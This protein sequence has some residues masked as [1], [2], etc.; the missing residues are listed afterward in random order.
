[1]QKETV[2]CVTSAEAMT[3]LDLLWTEY[4]DLS[5]TMNNCLNNATNM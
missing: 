5:L 3:G 2:T 4:P 1:M